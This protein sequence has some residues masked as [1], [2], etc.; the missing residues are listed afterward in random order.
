MS[1][2]FDFGAWLA[3]ASATTTS[4][5]ILQNPALLGKYESWQ[6][7]YSRASRTADER[8]AG[9]PDPLKALEAE[10]ERLLSQIEES[11]S[12][13][14]VRALT[15]DDERAILAAFPDP[16]GPE[17]FDE[18]PPRLTSSPTEA[19]AKAFS[20]GY[21][22]YEKRMAMWV[23]AHR[24]ELD[25]YGESLR[26][27]A[28][29]RGAERI[30]RAVVLIEQGGRQISKIT[31]EHAEQLPQAI[32]EAQVEVLL[33]AIAKASTDVP[34]VPMGPLSHGSESDPE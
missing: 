7:R 28:I 8:S 2:D 19:Q 4:V 34:E 3:G 12:V 9:E 32:G 18:R 29:S 22:A 13:W 33:Q 23:E 17:G 30:S 24:A 31:A 11:R 6:R 5:D 21:Q 20:Y 25:A 15:A 16:K 10:G 27:V 14:H 26:Q 1:E